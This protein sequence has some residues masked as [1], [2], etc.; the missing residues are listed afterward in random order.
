[1]AEVCADLAPIIKENEKLKAALPE[2]NTFRLKA[3][4]Q[5]SLGQEAAKQGNCAMSR[6]ILTNATDTLK[7]GASEVREPERS[8]LT[9]RHVLEAIGI[10]AYKKDQQ[11][12]VP[13]VKDVLKAF[14]IVAYKK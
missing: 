13:T 10:V 14:G 11:Q 6:I 12:P 7:Q 5:Q 1:M 3:T 2:T 4:L 9:I 8:P